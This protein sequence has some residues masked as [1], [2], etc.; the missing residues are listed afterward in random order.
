V[1]RSILRLSLA[2]CVAVGVTAPSAVA[3]TLDNPTG[4]RLSQAGGG[5]LPPLP[6]AKPEAPPEPPVDQ[7][8]A[9]CLEASKER[10]ALI[11]RGIGDI[12]SQ[13]P[14]WARSNPQDPRLAEVRRFITLHEM[15]LFRC[16][17]DI[18][19]IVLAG[20]APPLPARRPAGVFRA[21]RPEPRLPRQ[22]GVPLPVR[23]NTVL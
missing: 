8:T 2:A 9:A 21:K 15:L 14:E 1:R 19:R 5:P 13:G 3:Q 20:E 17:V 16:P 4:L 6:S 7:E 12:L 23:K 11:S 18:P 10:D 22:P